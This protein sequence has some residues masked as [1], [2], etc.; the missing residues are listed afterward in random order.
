LE[1]ALEGKL[2][3]AKRPRG[4]R[5]E[6]I[7][8]I[9]LDVPFDADEVAKVTGDAYAKTL[10][11]SDMPVIEVK[12]SQPLENF[13]ETGNMVCDIF[14]KL[15]ATCKAGKNQQVPQLA[16]KKGKAQKSRFRFKK[17]IGIDQPFRLPG[18][19]FRN[20]PRICSQPGNEGVAYTPYEELKKNFEACWKARNRIDVDMPFDR[21]EVS[22]V[23]G[24]AYTEQVS[25]SDV[26]VVEITAS[27]TWT[28]FVKR[29]PWSAISSKNWGPRAKPAPKPQ[30]A[31]SWPRKNASR[32][33]GF[34]IPAG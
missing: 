5:G 32:Q 26:P 17:L 19:H 8:P 7:D 30:N 31:P 25:R 10:G 33:K 13:C 23:T 2:I 34:R 11:P 14:K 4:K 24:E 29:A 6:L 3:E 18:S 28:D 15:G 27:E 20:R 1:Q 9:D 22:K 12:T 21:D 16:K